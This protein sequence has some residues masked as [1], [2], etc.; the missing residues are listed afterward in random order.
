[1]RP[2]KR[3]SHLYLPLWVTNVVRY[4]ESF[5]MG[6][7]KYPAFKSKVTAYLYLY[8]AALTLLGSTNILLYSLV[9]LFTGTTF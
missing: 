7:L 1:M 5:S 9:R 3:R 8:S 2:K 6:T 4:D